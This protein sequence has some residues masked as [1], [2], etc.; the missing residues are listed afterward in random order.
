MSNY[1]LSYMQIIGPWP[2]TDAKRKPW[3]YLN[4]KHK[5]IPVLTW[6]ILLCMYTKC[7][8][9]ISIVKMSSVC[10]ITYLYGLIYMQT[11]LDKYM[12]F[13]LSRVWNSEN[14]ILGLLV[15]MDKLVKK[16]MTSPH[17][18]ILTVSGL[19]YANRYSILILH[20][21]YMY[22]CMCTTK[23]EWWRE[24]EHCT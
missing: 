19:K 2:M 15:Q 11:I 5:F 18:H 1:F 6:F 22:I 14:S 8:E 20:C 12:Y 21:I 24:Y 23:F 9:Y 17:S 13:L 10:N 7:S 3:T 16:L 4:I